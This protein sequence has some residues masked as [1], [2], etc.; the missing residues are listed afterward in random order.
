[1][2]VAGSPP[3][4]LGSVPWLDSRADTSLFADNASFKSNTAGAQGGAI[5]LRFASTANLTNT[6]L[7]RDAGVDSRR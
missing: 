7:V 2:S 3:S 4:T 6:Q 1:M 5:S